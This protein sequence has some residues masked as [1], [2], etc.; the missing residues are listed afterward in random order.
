MNVNTQTGTVARK[1]TSEKFA[2]LT[3]EITGS[4]K[5]PDK[6][7]FKTFD[8]G[9]IKSIA[10]LGDGELVTVS[11]ILQS[12]KVMVGGKEVTE[13]GKDGKEWPVK[14]PM[15]KVTAVQSGTA[16]NSDSGKPPF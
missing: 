6:V 14:V 4:G 12:E 15:L 9:A 11:Y 7:D 8:Q 13:A 2:K 5:Y 3:L 1:Y 16:S 10:G